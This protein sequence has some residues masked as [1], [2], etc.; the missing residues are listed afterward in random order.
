MKLFENFQFSPEFGWVT[1][2]IWLYGAIL[3]RKEQL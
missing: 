1:D 3:W 2:T